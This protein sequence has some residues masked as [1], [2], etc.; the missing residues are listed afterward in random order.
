MHLDTV[1]DC[2]RRGCHVFHS[3]GQ[4]TKTTV[5]V[6]NRKTKMTL[7]AW[8][9]GINDDTVTARFSYNLKGKKPMTPRMRSGRVA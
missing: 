5:E 7:Q 1:R 4:L 8:A 3:V 2:G 9:A 6:S